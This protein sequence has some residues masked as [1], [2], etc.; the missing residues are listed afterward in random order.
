LATE[1]LYAASGCELP[2]TANFAWFK[3]A[4]EL[5]GV[6]VVA[7]APHY[8]LDYVQQCRNMAFAILFAKDYR[9]HLD[10]HLNL[11]LDNTFQHQRTLLTLLPRQLDRMHW[12]A[13]LHVTVGHPN[14]HCVFLESEWRRHTRAF[15]R[16]GISFVGTPPTDLYLLGRN[17]AQTFQPALGARATMPLPYMARLHLPV[18]MGV[19]HVGNAF[20]P[21]ESVDPLALCPLAVAVYQDS[22]DAT[23]RTLLA[24]YYCLFYSC[25]LSHQSN[26]QESVS[27]AAKAA[28]AVNN[29]PPPSLRPQCGDI[30][31]FVLLHDNDT[32]RDAA[33]RPSYARTTIRAGIVVA[34]RT[35]TIRMS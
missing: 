21:Q 25:P 8:E 17:T 33:L 26:A 1:P 16:H 23:L 13:D 3:R 32:L 20:A 34:S 11:D 24:R 15:L 14:A 10:L 22:S 9:R 30:A 4:M 7:S 19:G 35:T 18:A 6:D 29:S 12:P 28:I 2:D 31:D 27:V 5:P